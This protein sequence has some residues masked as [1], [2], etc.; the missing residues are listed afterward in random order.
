MILHHFQ[1]WIPGIPYD[2]PVLVNIVFTQDEVKDTRQSL[3][4]GNAS[5]PNGI[6]RVLKELM[7]ELSSPLYSLFNFFPV[8]KCFSLFFERG[9]CDSYSQEGWTLW[10]SNSRPISLLITIGQVFEKLV[11][12]HEFTVLVPR[13][14]LFFNLVSALTIFLQSFRRWKRGFICVLWYKQDLDRVWHKGFLLKHLSVSALEFLF[15]N[16][17]QIIFWIGSI[18]R[19]VLVKVDVPQ[20]SLSM[21]GACIIV[22]TC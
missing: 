9:K 10:V 5:G 13:G 7:F 12:K 22:D 20:G 18:L 4:L 11:H 17:F 19:L 14:Y 2:I 16:G 3:K 15:G 21:I 1:R 6:N 8:R